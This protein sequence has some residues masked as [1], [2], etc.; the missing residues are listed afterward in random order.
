MKLSIGALI[1]ALFL[2]GCAAVTVPVKIVTLPVRLAVDTVDH[3]TRAPA[4]F[5]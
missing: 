2:S 5:R 1:G 3:V 4:P